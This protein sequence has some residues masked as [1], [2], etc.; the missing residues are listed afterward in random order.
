MMGLKFAGREW[1]R[2]GH[3]SENLE[4][5]LSPRYI[6]ARFIGRI[7]EYISIFLSL[8]AEYGKVI[9]ARWEITFSLHEIKELSIQVIIIR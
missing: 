7:I 1:E 9:S 3:G 8:L 5:R 2:P 6:L 4:H